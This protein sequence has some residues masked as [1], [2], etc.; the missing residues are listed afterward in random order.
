[1]VRKSFHHPLKGG[2]W[3]P[4]HRVTVSHHSVCQRQIVKG[5][6]HSPPR[7][8]EYRLRRTEMEQAASCAFQ[9]TLPHR[10]SCQSPK[11]GVKRGDRRP[12]SQSGIQGCGGHIPQ[13]TCLVPVK[14]PFWRFLLTSLPQTGLSSMVST[15]SC[16]FSLSTAGE[17]VYSAAD[18]SLTCTVESLAGF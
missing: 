12:T 3:V 11:T 5:N 2:S 15:L 10:P 7:R 16:V 9:G 8:A 17:S 4:P 13:R 18:F 1:M 14:K 6:S